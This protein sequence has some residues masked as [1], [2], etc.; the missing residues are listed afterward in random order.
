M[1]LQAGYVLHTRAWRDNSLLVE[2]FSREQ[3]RIAM[4]AKGAKSRKQHGGSGAALLQP[5]TPLRCSWSGRTSLRNLTACETLGPALNL[6]GR[7]L[8]SGLY[9]NELL[10]RLL[11]HDDPHQK[12][13]DHY[14]AALALL[15]AEEQGDDGAGEEIPLRRFELVLLEELGYGFDLGTD[16]LHGEAL[17]EDA[18]Y[19]YHEGHGLVRAGIDSLERMPRYLGADLVRIARGDFSGGARQCAK[20]LMRQ[21]LNAHLG[22]EPL[23]S[24]ELFQRPA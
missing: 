14:A 24:R 3:G 2:F 12:L 6:K 21:V 9:L 23:K 5:F 10:T 19:H 8:Y 15:A 22:N 13:F 20:R 7:R 4:V 16:S 18:W 1:E 11:H 17:D